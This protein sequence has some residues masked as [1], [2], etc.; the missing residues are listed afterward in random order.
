M[1]FCLI[2]FCDFSTCAVISDRL[3]QVSAYSGG[4]LFQLAT[5]R[6][7]SVPLENFRSTNHKR[8][9]KLYKTLYRV[10]QLFEVFAQRSDE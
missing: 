6:F 8:S 10:S 9:F 2:Q 1:S 3:S 7:S 5:G 4:F